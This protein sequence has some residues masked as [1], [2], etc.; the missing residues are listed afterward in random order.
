[1]RKR[2][3][4]SVLL[5]TFVVLGLPSIALAASP[6]NFHKGSIKVEYGDLNIST[7]AGARTLYTRL[8]N[9]A[10]KGC[11]FRPLNELGSISRYKESRACYSEKLTAAVERIDSDTLTEIHNSK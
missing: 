11:D 1:M 9:A 10:R 3:P 7:L 5:A 8:E 6:S 4:A 2:V